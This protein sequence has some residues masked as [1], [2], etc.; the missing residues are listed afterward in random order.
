[1]SVGR[2][3]D[4]LDETR[5]IGNGSIEL[6]RRP[7]VKIHRHVVGAG[8]GTKRARGANGTRINH[9]VVPGNLAHAITR[10][11]R[12]RMPVSKIVIT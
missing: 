12:E 7:M 9:L 3:A 5:M 1:M 11:K 6:E 10:I 2:K 4:A 8:D